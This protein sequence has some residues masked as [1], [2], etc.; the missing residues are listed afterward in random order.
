MP[1]PGGTDRSQYEYGL[2]VDMAKWNFREWPKLD[3]DKPTSFTPWHSLFRRWVK[4]DR[5]CMERL[6]KLLEREVEPI[7][8]TR[9]DSFKVAAGLPAHW[10]GHQVSKELA[11]AMVRTG[12]DSVA[13]RAR[14]F[15]DSC[16]LELYR[17]VHARYRVSGLSKARH[18]TRP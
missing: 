12:T 1:A 15:G 7:D 16:G 5:E 14:E 3:L 8:R 11:D 9:E 6:F 18:S 17:W 2:K 4:D 13:A 10:D